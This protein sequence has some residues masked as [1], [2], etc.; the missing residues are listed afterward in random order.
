MTDVTRLNLWGRCCV[1]K[2]MST[3]GAAG[4]PRERVGPAGP[5]S[6][7][8]DPGELVDIVTTSRLGRDVEF[9]DFMAEHQSTLLRTAW[10]LCGDPHRAEE[11]TQEALVRTY[12]AWP[13]LR[14]DPLAYARRTLVN[15]R[16]DTWRRRRREVL[17][18]PDE[19]PARA[20]PDEHGT[21]ADRDQLV[22][23]L[24]ILSPRARRVVV[25]RHLVGLSE[26]EVSADLGVSIGTVKSTAS[27]GL[28]AVRATLATEDRR[29]S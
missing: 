4:E 21:A 28:A 10:L 16:V 12:G 11:L 20:A 27:R 3:M 8:T 19:L 22:R 17:T 5:Q 24:A 9:A 25:L 6:D 29:L 13:R 18:A 26:A 1:W 2:G 15:L 14:T 7:P 23:A